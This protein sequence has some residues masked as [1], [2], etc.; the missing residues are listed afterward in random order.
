MDISKISWIQLKNIN[1]YKLI[2]TM[3]IWLFIVPIVARLFEK[4][5]HTANITIFEYT[6]EAQLSLPFSW[7]IF[8]FSAIAFASANLIYQLRCPSIIKDNSDY[9]DFKQSHKGVEHLDSYLPQVGMN[10]EGLRQELENQDD[11]FNETAEASNPKTDDG[12]LRKRFWAVFSKGNRVRP[13]E[14]YSVALFYLIGFILI[15]WVF[16]QNINFVIN[17]L[18]N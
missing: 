12:I 7:V 16:V 9:S 17:F 13:I 14:K 6:F 2:N 10:W 15:F 1:K 11:Y 3:Y 18:I 8:Y 4:V 5:E